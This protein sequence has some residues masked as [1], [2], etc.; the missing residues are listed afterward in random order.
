MQKSITII[1]G[2]II[3]LS[4]A[5]KLAEAGADV[6][7]IEKNEVGY[8]CSYGNAGWMTPCFAMP[9]PMP[10]MLMK[11]M[12]WM[13]NPSG[14]LYIKPV[15]SVLLSQWL[16]RFLLSM[17]EAKAQIAI[18]ALVKLSIKSLQDYKQLA[19]EYPEI[20]MQQKGLLM[21][22]ATKDGVKA[23][24]QE[25]DLVAKYN[26]PGRFLTGEQIKEFEPALRG[27]LLGGVYFSQEAHAE[28][29]K[30][31][32][33]LAKK[34]QKLG[35][36][37]LEHTE[38]LKANITTD[39][40]TK[41]IKSI[42]TSNGEMVSDSFVLAAGS[43]SQALADEL[44][45]NVPI[46]GGKGYALIVD[47]LEAQPKVPI[48]IVDRKIAI[49]PRANSLRIAGTLELVNQDFSITERRV[50]AIFDGAKEFLQIPNDIKVHE[51]WRGLRPCT[52][53]GVP[54]I[55]WAKDYNNLM[56]ACGHQMLGLQAGL[57]TGQLVS[58]LVI[59][60]TS[61]LQRSVYD[62]ARF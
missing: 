30:V 16:T 53:D 21:V 18:E 62:P 36:Q 58:D 4:C 45:L 50:K 29:L 14:P 26:I 59:K 25:M 9:L 37:I 39:G 60:G 28:P 20:D 46:L 11:S 61:D 2:G 3:G 22:S 40:K 52:P 49:T 19:L 41:K 17:T 54:L 35:V 48:M 44:S 1:G 56:M 8:G 23:A 15:P 10:G 13:L 43:W 33:A 57:G 31:V 32:Q 24:T 5:V 51:T 12:K 34:A 38:F 55:G 42:Q 6:V 7:V 27:N 47:K